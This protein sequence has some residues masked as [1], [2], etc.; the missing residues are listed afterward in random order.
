MSSRDYQIAARYYINGKPQ[1]NVTFQ[2]YY[3]WNPNGFSE[4]GSSNYGSKDVYSALNIAGMGATIFTGTIDGA[5]AWSGSGQMYAS[6]WG[7]VS[8]HTSGIGTGVSLGAG[9]VQIYNDKVAVENNTDISQSERLIAKLL[10]DT[11]NLL[12][13]VAGG[14]LAGLAAIAIVAAAP[15]TGPAAAAAAATAFMLGYGLGFIGGQVV[16]ASGEEHGLLKRGIVPQLPPNAPDFM[17]KEYTE[18]YFYKDQMKIKPLSKD[19]KLPVFAQLDG[20]IYNKKLESPLVID[21]DGNGIKTSS[22]FGSNIKFD[23]Y[24]DGRQT[25]TGWLDGTDGFI[26]Y[27]VNNN[28]MIDNINEMYGHSSSQSLDD[29]ISYDVNM[30]GRIDIADPMH[31]KLMVWQDINQNGVSES[32]ELNSLASHGIGFILTSFR[33]DLQYNNGNVITD[34]TYADGGVESAR[35]V[36]DVWFQTATKL[37]LNTNLGISSYND[38]PNIAGSGLVEDLQKAMSSNTFLR[39]RVFNLVENSLSMSNKQ[40]DAEF[41]EVLYIWAGVSTISP[42]ARGLFIDARKIAVVEAFYGYNFNVYDINL[43]NLGQANLA[44]DTSNIID[45]MYDH[46]ISY[47]KSAFLSDAGYSLSA[48]G[49]EDADI[50]NSWILPY[51]AMGYDGTEG[52]FRG[53]FGIAVQAIMLHAK[54]V[55]AGEIPDSDPDGHLIASMLS[56][57]NLYIQENGS[58]LGYKNYI[59]LAMQ[60]AGDINLDAYSSSVMSQTA[61]ALESSYSNNSNIVNG[62]SGSL[63]GSLGS[64]FSNNGDEPN[65]TYFI[66]KDQIFTSIRDGD[67]VNIGGSKDLIVLVGVN[68]RDIR[69]EFSGNNLSGLVKDNNSWK[70]IITVEDFITSEIESFSFVDSELNMIDIRGKYINDQNTIGDDIINGTDWNDIIMLGKGNDEVKGN[71]GDDIFIYEKGD[72]D[73]K[74]YS[75]S[76]FVDGGNKKL[77]MKGIAREE[78]SFSTNGYDLTVSVG[79]TSN[80]SNIIGSV[81]L[82]ANRY[83]FNEPAVKTIEFDSGSVVMIEDAYALARAGQIT[84]GNDEITGTAGADIMRGGKGDDHLAGGTGVDTYVYARGDG[85]DIVDDGLVFENNNLVLH[86]ITASEMRVAFVGYDVV[87]SFADSAAGAG[88]AGSIRFRADDYWHAHALGTITFDDGTV[89]NPSQWAGIGY[90]QANVFHP[91]D[92]DRTVRVNFTDGAVHAFLL[93]GYSPDQVSVTGVDYLGQITL[94]MVNATA[95]T[96]EAIHFVNPPWEKGVDQIQF[97]NGAVWTRDDLRYKAYVDDG[98]HGSTVT[99]DTAIYANQSAFVGGTGD[100]IYIVDAGLQPVSIADHGGTNALTLRGVSQAQVDFSVDAQTDELVLAIHDV[101]GRNDSVVKF[102]HGLDTK[103]VA[104]VHFD[105]GSMTAAEIETWIDTHHLAA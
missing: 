10:D 66:Q 40:F 31:A 82:I 11:N 33:K 97:D 54:F 102:A 17:A 34:V 90:D 26:V 104:A 99:L 58:P 22:L 21:L 101:P 87:I 30:D 45:K 39:S 23:Y 32:A 96:T 64:N 18:K 84:D 59:Q 28:G 62:I 93:H 41:Q 19:S 71:R 1:D 36:A 85:N 53:N 77:I 48:M 9:V 5:I 24:T 65:D 49:V 15:V 103:G 67:E 61:S 8:T 60:S 56:L 80:V 76:G 81:D 94:S 95:G 79:E 86:G 51:I 42:D 37:A 4:Y 50:L 43:N 83:Y 29:F 25:R 63:T 47:Y 105:D 6:T 38:L 14:M 7:P 3:G 57:M 12:Y 100:T 20:D 91:G 78:I 88:D 70:K 68:S 69:F 35:L 2:Q 72:G 73:D 75:T 74:V 13:G 27:D 98:A 44:P 55:N 89:L 46:I 52:L 92:G 16:Y